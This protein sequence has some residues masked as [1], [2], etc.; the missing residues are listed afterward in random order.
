VQ[1]LD[2]G[3]VREE[4]LKIAVAVYG[5]HRLVD[6]VCTPTAEILGKANKICRSRGLDLK[7]AI[8]VRTPVALDWHDSVFEEHGILV[9]DCDV[10][11][12]QLATLDVGP[13]LTLLHAAFSRWNVQRAGRSAGV[14]QFK[15]FDRRADL[16]DYVAAP[17][18]RAQLT[19]RAQDAHA[20]PPSLA[21]SA[22]TA[23][24]AKLASLVASAL[25]ANPPRWPDLEE[26]TRAD[27]EV[28]AARCMNEA[29]SAAAEDVLRNFLGVMES[30]STSAALALVRFYFA[31]RPRV[32]PAP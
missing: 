30:G 16:A 8:V 1:E 32:P 18:T 19:G 26:T 7:D 6:L 15:P 31:A 9:L 29:E 4:G 14:F 24:G 25:H 28:I 10:D 21:A 20:G 5:P 3:Q 13:C 17:L 27:L 22:Q 11:C 23:A 2:V 12:T